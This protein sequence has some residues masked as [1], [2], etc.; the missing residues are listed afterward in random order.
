MGRYRLAMSVD[1]SH[2]ESWV[3]DEDAAD[4]QTIRHMLALT[5][6]ERLRSLTNFYRL[7]RAR[8]YREPLRARSQRLD[9]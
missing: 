5:P 4:R 1:G 3:V 6:A 9:P 8:R 2:L 7:H